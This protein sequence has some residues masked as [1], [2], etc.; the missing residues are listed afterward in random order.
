MRLLFRRL[1]WSTHGTMSTTVVS[2]ECSDGVLTL[3][4]NR[5][6]KLN[7]MNAELIDGVIAG[8]TSA[9]ADPAVR[10]IVLTGNGRAFSAG[11]DL[12]ATLTERRAGVASTVATSMRTVEMFSLMEWMPKPVIA[13]VNGLTYAGALGF[14]LYS[15][16][17]LAS[18][19]AV[20]CCPMTSRGIYEPYVATRLAARVG[21]ERAKYM[22]MTAREITAPQALEWGMVSEVHRTAAL[23]DATRELSARLSTHD[24]VSMREYKFAVRRALP[25][26]D[27]G[28]FV[29]QAVAPETTSLMEEFA[30]QF[31]ARDSG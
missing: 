16:L 15:D 23:A 5:P 31:P 28:T 17:S 10:V 3:R 20:F 6:E 19:E 30:R 11:G 25:G 29:N 7:A 13:M 9:A 27:L 14:V 24:P 18:E 2:S 4:L 21:V 8:L 12:T 22:L 1:G 26:F